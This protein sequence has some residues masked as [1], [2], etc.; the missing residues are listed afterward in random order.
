MNKSGCLEVTLSKPSSKDLTKIKE[1]L[2]TQE[3]KSKQYESMC[4]VEEGKHSHSIIPF[5]RER[6]ISKKDIKQ[7]SPG[8]L[9]RSKSKTLDQSLKKLS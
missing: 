6:K 1:K 4:E 9:I 8:R 2:R 3:Q 7:N 5:P